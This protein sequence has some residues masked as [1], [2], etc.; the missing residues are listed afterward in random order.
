MLLLS[1]RSGKTRKLNYVDSEFVQTRPKP[2]KI[3]RTRNSLGAD[4]STQTAMNDL[5]PSHAEDQF[6][7]WSNSENDGDNKE[8]RHE[9]SG[10]FDDNDASDKDDGLLEGYESDNDDF[11]PMQ[12]SNDEHPFRVMSRVL[13]GSNV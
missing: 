10:K 6:H 8:A 12:S 1:L 9:S 7:L 5:S 11:G 2:R 3:R 4:L 13:G